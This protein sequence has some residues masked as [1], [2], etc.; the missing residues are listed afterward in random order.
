MQIKNGT[1]TELAGIKIIQHLIPASNKKARPGYKMNPEHITIHNTGNPGASALANSKYVD[2]V[3]GYVSWH[4]TV[5]SGEVYQELP[6]IESA[7]HAG[8]GENGTG[9]RK[10]IGIE[11]AEVDGAE[12]TAI[13]FVAQLIKATGIG[14]D[15]VVPH[16]HWSG[17]NCPRLIL[18]HW[19]K[20]IADIKN[21][22]EP[23]PINE[24][25][26][27]KNISEMPEFYQG[28]IKKWVA[29]GYIKGNKDG[30]LDFTEDMIRCLIISER[31]QENKN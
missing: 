22:L 16:Q 28:Y 27:Y 24:I 12:E 1:V 5:G 4:F 17:K 19:D 8:D 25:K 3:A 7:W 11:I 10:S 14:I 20:F 26:R 29:A 31:M 2:T 13:K 23:R 18:P 9:N 30:T 15:K 21:E 6:I